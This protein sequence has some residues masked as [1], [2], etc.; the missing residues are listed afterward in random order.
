MMECCVGNAGTGRTETKTMRGRW[1]KVRGTIVESPDAPPGATKPTMGRSR[2]N[3]D[4]VVEV[5][6]RKGQVLRATV[7]MAGFFV[8][9]VGEPMAV[10]VNFKTGE[11]RL[12]KEAEAGILRQQAETKRVEA[13]MALPAP[14][15]TG[16][17]ET[18]DGT[19]T[20]EGR[21]AQLKQLHDKGILTESEY[22]AKR[23]EIISQL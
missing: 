5:Q 16:S 8:H 19:G 12:D 21:L 14:A 18:A 7:G 1:E 3:H 2:Q 15:V 9:A 20:A 13:S 4:Y 23:A 11:V 22:Q 6:D 10:E 17:F